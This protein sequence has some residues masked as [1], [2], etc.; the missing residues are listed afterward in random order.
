MHVHSAVTNGHRPNYVN[1]AQLVFHGAH[2]NI[3]ITF[4]STG[5]C[6]DAANLLNAVPQVFGFQRVS[7][8]C[9]S[10]HLERASPSSVLLGDAVLG[11]DLVTESVV[12]IGKT[13]A[14]LLQGLK[15]AVLLPQSLLELR[16]LAK[17][18]SIAETRLA[19]L[20]LGVTGGETLVLLLKTQDF[21]DHGVGAVEDEGKEEGEAAQ[22][23]V[24]LGVELA[25]LNLHAFAAGNG[26]MMLSVD[27]CAISCKIL[28]LPCGTAL[29]LGHGELDLDPVDA[30]DAVNEQDEDED[31][32]DL[33]Y[34]SDRIFDATTF[35]HTF[36]PY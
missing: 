18:T 7:R 23:H 30:V 14:L 10:F 3:S 13:L 6:I 19:L 5:T 25:G 35:C 22:V 15:L 12:L 29:L 8:R 24:A 20:A 32:C 36:I 34:V 1:L 26:A 33:Q 31:K 11:A 16:N 17:L 28:D 9:L 4:S 21:E 27:C 2:P